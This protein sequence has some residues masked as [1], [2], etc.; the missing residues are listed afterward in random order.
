VYG[1]WRYDEMMSLIRDHH[2][3]VVNKFYKGLGMEL[4]RRESDLMVELLLSLKADDIVA[5]PIHDG[6]LVADDY[7]E[8]ARIIMERVFV[9]IV[10]VP[11]VVN[12]QG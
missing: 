10:G 8:K 3:E 9:D 2:P 12:D 7:Q 11:V 1:L 4:M 6:I 5:L